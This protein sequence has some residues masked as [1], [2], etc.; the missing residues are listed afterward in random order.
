MRI[1]LFPPADPDLHFY[2][3]DWANAL[4]ELGVDLVIFEENYKE[5]AKDVNA[6]RDK[7]VSLNPD[8]VLGFDL[9]FMGLKEEDS[10]LIRPI[11]ESLR[12]PYVSI[13]TF[14]N[15]DQISA[16]ASPIRFFRHLIG[17][18]TVSEW[19]AVW[20]EKILSRDCKVADFSY[21]DV[22]INF[23]EWEGEDVALFQ[24]MSLQEK[25]WTFGQEFVKD[26]LQ[27]IKR[28]IKALL[29][30]GTQV[31]EIVSLFRKE[32]L[33]SVLSCQVIEDAYWQWQHELFER[34]GD[35]LTLLGMQAVDSLLVGSLENMVKQMRKFRAVI[36][37]RMR[38]SRDTLD[39]LSW[40]AL[41][42]GGIPLVFEVE[43]PKVDW[44]W[45]VRSDLA[46]L[47]EIIER[48]SDKRVREE[49]FWTMY[50][51]FQNRSKFK[52]SVKEVLEWVEEKI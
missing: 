25:R 40:F 49:I 4:L 23:D 33:W 46:N 37:T 29:D 30:K 42:I 45:R 38:F 9:Y 6:V 5:L 11:F 41:R 12:I 31:N 48:L 39:R 21:P 52:E 43:F 19:S 7:I 32:I 35:K 1:V 24:N 20:I 36:G 17:M 51:F 10:V 28:Q 22:R 14:N 3:V 8:L 13:F 18:V 47:E 26:E 2:Y 50:S 15:L 16:L 27:E 44:W 34:I